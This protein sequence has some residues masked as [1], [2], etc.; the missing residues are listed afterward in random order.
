MEF[1]YQAGAQ[2][3]TVRIER[4]ND[5]N[6]YTVAI[7]ERR[8]TVRLDALTEASV[9]FSLDGQHHHAWITG[10]SARRNVAFDAMVHTLV[11]ADTAQRR[12]ANTADDHRLDAT[13]PGQV[14]KVLVA[15][16]EQVK[17]G[18]ALV[19]LEAMKMEMRVAAPADGSVTKV[20]CS[21]GQV[22]ERGQQ[23]I[24]FFAS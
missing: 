7:G 4:A 2:S 6:H 21:V 3:Y 22:V 9:Q 15:A 14:V 5:D 16:G 24:E 18:Q 10:D 23:L 11:K 20:L 8:Y 19:V 12:K 13:M 1:K 17:R